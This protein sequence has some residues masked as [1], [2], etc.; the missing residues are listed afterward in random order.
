MRPI[1]LRAAALL[2]AT[3][4]AACSTTPAI[5]NTNNIIR[6]TDVELICLEVVGATVRPHP[7]TRCTLSDTDNGPGGN[8]TFHM[9]AVVPQFD[10]GELAVIDLATT[11]GVALVDNSPATPGYSFLP[12]GEFPVAIASDI[13]DG[14]GFLYVA[15]GRSDRVLRLD[16]AALRSDPRRAAFAARRMELPVGG[17]PRDLALVVSGDRHLLVATLPE[18]RAVSIVDVT[19]PAAPGAPRII[20]LRGA[21]TGGD[22]GVADGGAMALPHPV[23]LAVDEEGGRAYVTDDVLDRVHVVDVAAGVELDSLAVG[24]R[25]RVAVVTGLARRRRYNCD[26][27]LDPDHCTRSRYLYLTT[28]DQGDVIVWDLTRGARVRPNVLPQPNAR[29]SRIEPSIAVDRVPLLVPATALVAIN[30]SAYDSMAADIPVSPPTDSATCTQ[31]YSPTLGSFSGVFVGAV[32]RSGQLAIIDV[33]DYNV[34]AWEAQCQVGAGSTLTGPYRF[35]RHAPHAKTQLTLAPAL[36]AAPTTTALLRGSARGQTLDGVGAP[37]FACGAARSIDATPACTEANNYGVAL[38]RRQIGA[39]AAGPVYGPADPF[40]S[41]NEAWAFAFEGIIPGLDQT[42]G[43]LTLDPSGALSLEAPGGF[44]CTRGAL[45]VDNVARDLLSIVSDPTPLAA[46]AELCAQTFGAGEVPLN[47]DLGIER[48]F[49]DRLQLRANGA[50][51][52]ALVVR[53]YPQAIRFQVRA[54]QQWIAQGARS[55]FLHA[56][57]IGPG[58]ECEVDPP[59]QAEVVAFAERCLRDR[60]TP[61]DQLAAQLARVCPAGRACTGAVVGG[62]AQRDLAPVFANPYLCTQIF[63]ALL[64]R[65]TAAGGTEVVAAPLDRDTQITFTLANAWDAFLTDVGS[66]PVAAR[67]LRGLDRLYVVDTAI[68]GLMEFRFNPFERGRIFN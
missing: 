1:S 56:V 31:G 25:T 68:N 10:R 64:Q 52:A 3:L 7:T 39:N 24:E 16:A 62:M 2:G 37:L 13:G 34:D 9:H 61:A 38:P 11:A 22:A 6:A 36:S 63:P 23:A 43:A 48:A 18:S 12:V 35:V 44:F 57:R 55:G 33:D 4:A 32:L 21:A 8:P 67:H 5:S 60:A 49:E 26:Q 65:M 66:L 46:D 27:A 50:D 17:L 53:C 14:T 28:A 19:D 15:S 42:G 45:A 20:T 29:G 30:T 54:S 51:F 59:K 40:T 41:R 47:R 58:R